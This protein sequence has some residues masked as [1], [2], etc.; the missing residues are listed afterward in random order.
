MRLAVNAGWRSE[1]GT[2]AHAQERERERER[3][4]ENPCFKCEAGC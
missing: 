1:Y 4:R 3:E 2:C